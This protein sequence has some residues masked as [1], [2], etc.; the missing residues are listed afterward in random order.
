MDSIHYHEAMTL[1]S[2]IKLGFAGTLVLLGL[3][4][5]LQNT[6][7]VDTKIL[8]IT[9][10]MPRALLLFLTLVIG[11]AGGAASALIWTHKNKA[12]KKTDSLAEESASNS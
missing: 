6:D 1:K 8:F 9:V 5:V 2:K 4:I 7:S 11:F 10:S 3:I 12:E